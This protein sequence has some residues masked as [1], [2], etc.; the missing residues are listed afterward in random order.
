MRWFSF[1]LT[2]VL[3]GAAPLMAGAERMAATERPLDGLHDTSQVDSLKDNELRGT[4]VSIDDGQVLY[5]EYHQWRGAWHRAE[6]RASDG[7]LL[8]VNELDYSP[9][10][11]Q[12]AFVQTD[13]ITGAR[14]GARWAGDTLTLFHDGRSEV[15]DYREPLVISSGFNNFVLEH[16]N[17]LID[18]TALTVEFA[19]PERLMLVNLKVQRIEPLQSH[20][21]ERHADWIYLRVKP[22]SII[23]NWLVKPVDLA[24]N[25][26]RRLRIYRG[27][28]NLEIA[29]K[30][31]QVEIR[32]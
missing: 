2:L 29:G 27:S 8:A 11:S 12:P 15:V 10:K 31:P 4:A 9:G 23:L 20:I 32:Y 22:A 7:K 6:Y 13:E 3:A 18:N 28:S 24:Y 30:V 14:R 21:A 19:V 1:C 17:D 16:W 26:D 25:P 5:T